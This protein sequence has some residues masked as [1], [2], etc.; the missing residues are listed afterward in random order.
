ML[1]K[2]MHAENQSVSRFEHLGS[3]CFIALFRLHLLLRRPPYSFENHVNFHD[4]LLSL[5]GRGVSLPSAHYVRIGC[6][7]KNRRDNE[8]GVVDI[9]SVRSSGS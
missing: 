2:D 6:R 7:F 8:L 5:V 1:C 4:E 3:L 9:Q